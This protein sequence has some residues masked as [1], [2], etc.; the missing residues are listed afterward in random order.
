MN[1]EEVITR[2]N[3]E[4]LRLIA[5]LT[6]NGNHEYN[7]NEKKIARMHGN[8]EVLKWGRDLTISG[9]KKKTGNKSALYQLAK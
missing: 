6:H 4:N 9:P 5:H 1:P 8:I 3:E 2:M 7:C